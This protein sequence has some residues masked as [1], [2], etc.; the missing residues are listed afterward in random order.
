VLDRL[1]EQL[2]LTPAQK[3]QARDA[4]QA[5]RASAGVRPGAEASQAER[6][7]YMR[8]SREASLR[9]IEPILTPAQKVKLAA[10]RQTAP[11][12]EARTRTG[13][14]WVLRDNKPV[15]VQV[16]LGVAADAFTEV[17]SGLGEGDL[18]I[19]GGGPVSKEKQKQQGGPMGAPG[20]GG[21]RVR[22][23]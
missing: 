8:K 1:A 11:A 20:G 6:R 16:E 4:M 22:G 13:V 21:V 23:T 3:D 10:I 5:A 7:A 17:V 2:E 14:V 12:G 19:T 9:A 18:V 15:P